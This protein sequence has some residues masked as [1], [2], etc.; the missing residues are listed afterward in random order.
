ME[1]KNR[2]EKDTERIEVPFGSNRFFFHNLSTAGHK[3]SNF[4]G[5][6]KHY[7]NSCRKISFRATKDF[8]LFSKKTV[9]SGLKME[10]YIVCLSL[11]LLATKSKILRSI[12]LLDGQPS[13]AKL[14]G[15][16]LQILHH[17][18]NLPSLVLKYPLAYRCPFIIPTPMSIHALVLHLLPMQPGSIPQ[19]ETTAI[20]VSRNAHQANL[21][22]SKQTKVNPKHSACNPSP[23]ALYPSKIT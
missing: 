23:L 22:L 13:E 19:S 17:F 8:Y 14:N 20:S 6:W 9:L 12:F 5:G 21:V 11:P 16:S 7:E 15:F 4:A 18:I 1:W 2:N 3:I 10:P